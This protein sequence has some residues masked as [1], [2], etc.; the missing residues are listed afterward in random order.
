MA[1]IETW[2]NQDLQEAVKVRYIDGNVFSADNSGNIIGINVFNGGQPASLTGS[3][4][5]SIIR[6]D[7]VTVSAVGV[8]SG[9]RVSVVLPQA[10]YVCPGV[11]SVVLKIT[12]GTDITTV[13]AVVGNVYRSTT[14]SVVDPGTIIPSIETLIAEIQA[15]VASIP[16][17]YSD[18][19][20]C[21]AAP[22]SEN[23]S[24]RPGDYVTYDGGFYRFMYAHSGTWASEDVI[25]RT[26]GRIAE[27]I[28]VNV[29]N[30]KK[31]IV[32][33]LPKA[34]VSPT[35]IVGLLGE[36]GVLSSSTTYRASTSSYLKMTSHGRYIALSD[37]TYS[38]TRI[39]TYKV[40]NNQYVFSRIY[41][42]YGG[43][44][45]G[46]NPIYIPPE[47]SNETY[48]R[49]SI[50]LTSDRWHD[51][52]SSDLEAISE[53]LI[54][55][56]VQDVAG[57]ME[58]IESRLNV[59][60]YT[61]SDLDLPFQFSNL[62]PGNTPQV[63]YTENGTHY[64]SMDIHPYAGQKIWI[65][66]PAVFST[67]GVYVFVYCYDAE[68]TQMQR[69]DLRSDNYSAVVDLV[70]IPSWV[71]HAYISV[72]TT[73]QT[74]TTVDGL[75]IFI[76]QDNIGETQEDGIYYNPL[77][78]ESGRFYGDNLDI[79]WVESDGSFLTS[80]PLHLDAGDI[81]TC[82]DS[83]Y[84]FVI[85]TFSSWTDKEHFTPSSRTYYDEGNSHIVRKSDLAFIQVTRDDGATMLLDE[86]IG[87][88]W[89]FTGV[90]KK[91]DGDIVP[92]LRIPKNSADYTTMFEQMV[93]SYVYEK[94]LLGNEESPDELPIYLYRIKIGDLMI[95]G[96]EYYIDQRD[97]GY[98]KK[99]L[100]NGSIHGN[101]KE[102]SSAILSFLLTM[103]QNP[104]YSWLL[105]KFE[106]YIIPV[107]N[108]WGYS[109]H[110]VNAL[111]GEPLYRNMS[112]QYL[113]P[114]GEF[115]AYENTS[116]TQPGIRP[117][118][119]GYNINRDFSDNEVNVK[120][121][122]YTPYRMY[123]FK[124]NEA[125]ILRNLMA[126]QDFDIVIDVHQHI[127]GRNI[128][129]EP[130]RYECG[131][132]GMQ[133]AL[134]ASPDTKTDPF[135][136]ASMEACAAADAYLEK[137]VGK[138]LENKGLQMSFVWGRKTNGVYTVLKNYAAGYAYD[139]AGNTDHQSDI[140]AAY[141]ITIETSQYCQTLAYARNA[142][143]NIYTMLYGSVYVT[144]FITSVLKKLV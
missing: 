58:T 10:A 115:P 103:L 6:E 67:L 38:I 116:E 47:N 107:S 59:R 61:F 9:N 105:G 19:W 137:Y 23:T 140:K 131:M 45:T 64:K 27:N 1:R 138:P 33:G 53:K 101:E 50:M 31:Q 75:D 87:I 135:Y 54:V 83:D 24:Y 102:S 52:T 96:G 119:L 68:Y 4:S 15:A 63:L 133:Q 11:I 81:I 56:N 128:D 7:G 79:Q 3:V 118:Y 39:C 130:D 18:L 16:A 78:F 70:T 108:P 132:A 121:S 82:T 62:Y 113:G 34:D 111:T 46:S 32:T 71:K 120:A 124:T 129:T 73:A 123:G 109:H 92:V 97:L 76:T 142:P 49:V 117:N 25:S 106:F 112:D 95:P 40:V 22:F 44:F 60:H 21:L 85:F 37:D 2:F 36:D 8:L 98:R 143:M 125:M 13:G 91:Y 17:D 100:I 48:F 42:T 127:Y 43:I 122:D 55:Y 66:S 104:K 26:V 5:A 77:V 14:D 88:P 80:I 90:Q 51:M 35:I 89:L 29:N 12:S 74:V 94:T 20:E 141:G 41:P 84:K 65:E 93:P 126:A 99:V 69:F 57:D 139:N 110:C 72:G 136:I 86:R 30:I 134:S 114:D 144:E 28:D